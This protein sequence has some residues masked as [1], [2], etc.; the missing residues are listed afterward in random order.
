MSG[1]VG[2]AIYKLGM[3]ENVGVAVG[4]LRHLFPFKSYFYFRFRGRHLSFRCRPM[5][6][7]VGSA[8]CRSGVV[9]NVRYQLEW[10]C[11]LFPFTSY[12]Y[13]QF[14]HVDFCVLSRH[15]GT[16]GISTHNA[17]TSSCTL[18]IWLLDI[19]YRIFLSVLSGAVRAIWYVMWS[20]G[21]F[22]PPP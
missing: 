21:W 3:V 4:S 17:M 13:V 8:I 1:H 6:G 18:F 22:H 10:R 5:L 2:N 16:F 15:F 12:C 7:N 14:P 11:Y 19:S 20:G 9:E